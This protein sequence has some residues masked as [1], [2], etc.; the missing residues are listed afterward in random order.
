LKATQTMTPPRRPFLAVLVL[1]AGGGA[2]A[3]PASADAGGGATGRLLVTLDPP[4]PGA[5]RAVA[6]AGQLV[7]R[8]GGRIARPPV[9]E[10]RLVS[11]R[12]R[13]GGSLRG[14]ARRLRAQPGVRS[15]Q[16]EHRYL[17][18]ALPDDPALSLQEPAPGTP[19]GVPVEWWAARQ[20]LP[21]AW[22]VPQTH[23]A[24]V[25][26]IDT[27]VDASH[28]DLAGRVVRAI[29]EDETPGDG[30]ATTDEVG[31]GTHVASLACATPDNG[32]GIA[33]AAYGCRLLVVKTDLTDTSVAASIV[34]ATQQGAEAINM[35]FGTTGDQ[36]ASD[37]VRTALHYAYD[38]GVVLVAAAADA[39]V[40]EQGDPSNV[41]QPTGSG[42]DATRGLG[43]SVT[44][45]NFNDQR[46]SF[47]GL[48]SQIS[49][50]AYGAWNTGSGGP[51]G[52]LGAFPAPTV[53]LERA[54]P[55][56][57]P[58]S[59]CNCRTTFQADSRYAYVQGTSMASPVVAGVAA[60]VKH[61]NPDLTAAE[62]IRLLKQTARR[63]AGTAWSPELGW[64]ILDAADAVGA[65]RLIDRRSPAT[66][67]RVL[68]PRSQTITLR[69]AGADRAPSGVR[70]SGLARI[71]VFRAVDGKPARLVATTT[72]RV[73]RLRVRRGPRYAFT[74]V[75]VD[76][77]GNREKRPAAPDARL[78]LKPR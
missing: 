49:L 33:G 36:P 23:G 4:R 19:S 57:P 50:A 43:L 67:L 13:G 30:P 47:A 60:M 63:P 37:A 6:A 66:R 22:D 45:A 1:L 2:L 51:R 38:R 72:K 59:A 75:G 69:L 70:A 48:G 53:A 73:L 12:P 28:P 35:S 77:A 14:L 29:D 58:S 71:E 10:L 5:P 16:A 25:A 8:A 44:A 74:A 32:V 31:H 17:L 24:T 54:E 20:G 27:G 15:V 55:G 26:V 40:E 46:A 52:L 9:P 62:V 78:R 64:G 21:A 65:A 18:R 56:P 39:P 41:L 7:G 3:G 76:K 68:T 61:L 11:V 34:Q 42:A